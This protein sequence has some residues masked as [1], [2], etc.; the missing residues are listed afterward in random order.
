[1]K[2]V[3]IES[4]FLYDYN[5]PDMGVTVG[6]TQR[7]TLDLGKLFYKLGY[8]VI[9]IT[10][11]NKNFEIC[12]KN[13]AKIIAFDSPYGTKGQISFSKRVY[14][15][16]NLIK[17]DI[18][19]Y[20]DL[21]IGWPF[22]YENSFALQHGIG[23]DTPYEKGKI[24]KRFLL[25]KSLFKF[26]K[27]IC[28][29][30]N[31]I[32][33]CRERYKKYFDNRDM[34]CYIPNYAD[35]NS[36]KVRNQKYTSDEKIL[37]FPR[38]LVSHRGAKLFMDI[39]EELTNLG[40]NVKGLFAIQNFRNEDFY[41]QFPN[42]K[43]CKIEVINPSLNEIFEYY[44]KSYLTIIPT[45]WSEGTSL[46]AIESICSGVPVIVSD[47]GGLG[48]LV[49][50]NYNG[51]ICSPCKDEFVKVIREYLDDVDFRNKVADNCLNLRKS[52]SKERWEKQII[53]YLGL[54]FSGEKNEN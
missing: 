41:K 21:E 12:Y 49:I 15:Y 17:P 2:R 8:E 51:E 38:R 22:C 3:I 6:G 35:L 29:D 44:R 47:V 24:I 13:W 46:S 40:Y 50:P 28:V 19:C 39:L 7:Y 4:M 26:K 16:C 5:N 54:N 10:K 11:A 48:N 43:N 18:V 36:I 52:F 30:T 14:D 34:L 45:I 53:S 9:Y 1:M 27:V 23:W 37:F 25:K 20:S 42:H 31:F 32:N 33:W